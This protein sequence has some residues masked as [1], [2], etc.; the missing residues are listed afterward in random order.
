MS[1]NKFLLFVLYSVFGFNSIAQN[2]TLK[3]SDELDT[4]VQEFEKEME[5]FFSLEFEINGTALKST[6]TNSVNILPNLTVFDTIH[7]SF[8][9]MN[10]KVYS[11]TFLCQLRAEEVYTISPCVCCGVFLMTPEKNAKRGFVKFINKSS[12]EYLYVA[13][14]IDSD[15]LYK[16]SD[17]D[18]IFSSIS[19]NCGFRPNEIFVANFEYTNQEYQYENLKTKSAKEKVELHIER[20]SHITYRFNFL[21]LHEEK[22]ILT[23]TED[24]TFELRRILS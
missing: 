23:I 8:I 1:K 12:F 17:T 20:E 3:I 13:S 4:F 22:L 9:D 21:F 16:N 5:L 24:G 11:E 15:T 14:E 10:G 18:Y 6:D 2:C 7:Y 19:M